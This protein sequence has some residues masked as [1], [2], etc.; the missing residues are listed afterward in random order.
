MKKFRF[1]L[2]TLLKLRRSDR[3]RCRQ[4]LVEVLR[5]DAELSAVRAWTE[6]ERRT[7][8]DELRTLGSGGA[9]LDVDASAARRHYAVQ[10]SGR[11]GELDVRGV[12][13]SREIDQR[14]QALVRAD[15]LVRA[16]ENL[17]EHREAE[18]VH[19]QERLE[20]RE[21]EQAWQ[22]IRATEASR[23]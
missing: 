3:D 6:A 15:Q 12:A 11:L 19:S 20:A 16:L 4:A 17:A 5:Q 2:E 13:L 18:F 14:R 8:I 21:L 7:Q 23:C 9:E 10:L 1:Q 22:A